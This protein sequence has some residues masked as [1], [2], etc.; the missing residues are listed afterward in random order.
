MNLIR[1]YPCTVATMAVVAVSACAI[2]DDLRFFPEEREYLGACTASPGLEGGCWW[3]A[4]R[5][6]GI[7]DYA[8]GDDIAY[9]G[10]Y[11]IQRDLVIIRSRDHARLEFRLSANEDTLVL[12]EAVRMVRQRHGPHAQ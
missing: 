11:G 5:A 6:G 2:G 4:F 12:N 3:A 1:Q 8:T 10:Q 7:V 9:R